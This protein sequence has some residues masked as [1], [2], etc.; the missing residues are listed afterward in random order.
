MCNNNFLGGCG[1]SWII[2]LIIILL[3]CCGGNGYG[4]SNNNGCGCGCDNGC[5]NS[6]CYFPREKGLQ[7]AAPFPPVPMGQALIFFAAL[8]PASGHWPIDPGTRSA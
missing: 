8:S 5:G 3:C 4:Y 1:C 7:P 2:I 6:C